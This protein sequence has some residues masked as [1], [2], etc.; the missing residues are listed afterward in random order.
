MI[1]TRASLLCLILL[2]VR[3]VPAQAQ[4]GDPAVGTWKGTLVVA[5]QSL[6]LVFHVVGLPGALSATFDSPAQRGFG[7]PIDTFKDENGS[8]QFASMRF[9][10]L[11]NGTMSGDKIAGTFTQ[12]G[13]SVPFEIVRVAVQ[14]GPP[15]Q[16]TA[17]E[18]LVGTWTGIIPFQQ[19]LRIVLHV[20]SSGG[21][22][23]TAT[24]DSP[25][26]N[27]SGIPVEL[28]TINGNVVDFS[29][30]RVGAHFNG[31]LSGEAISGT[32]SQ[33]VNVPLMLTRTP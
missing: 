30:A 20:Q 27:I 9:D 25:D 2:I 7:V 6:P 18:R 4:N 8:I 32:F 26:Q 5:G 22:G 21:G 28:I 29:M 1:L 11:F 16:N 10:F 12:R 33:G 13:V 31:T 23:L 15:E 3:A 17:P 24:A 14:G 19:P